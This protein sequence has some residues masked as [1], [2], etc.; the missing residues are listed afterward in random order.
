MYVRF[1]DLF[2]ENKNSVLSPPAYH[3]EAAGSYVVPLK[4][5]HQPYVFTNIIDTALTRKARYS[6]TFSV[7]KS[8][9]RSIKLMLL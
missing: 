1:L 8:E 5:D 2:I 9:E 6:C 7:F 3:K 4:S